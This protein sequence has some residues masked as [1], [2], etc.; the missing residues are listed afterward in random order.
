MMTPTFRLRQPGEMSITDRK[1]MLAHPGCVVT[2]DETED[3]G[4]AERE[5][6]GLENRCHGDEPCGSSIL[7]PSARGTLG[8][9]AG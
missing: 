5:C 8:L 3:G 9:R 4:L 7:S 6:D 1:N 2:W